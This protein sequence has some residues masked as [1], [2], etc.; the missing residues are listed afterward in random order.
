[1]GIERLL[2]QKREIIDGIRNKY[3]PEWMDKVDLPPSALPMGG[4]QQTRT[5]LRSMPKTYR[6]ESKWVD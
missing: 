6:G 5:P 3:Q 1:M 4:Q 2:M